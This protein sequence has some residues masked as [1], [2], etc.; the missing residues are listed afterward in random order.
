MHRPTVVTAL[1]F[2][3]NIGE[4]QANIERAVCLL[5][6][7][8]DLSLLKMS[9]FFRTPPWGYRDQDWFVN[10]CALFESTLDPDRLLVACKRI[11]DDLGRAKS[12]RW[13]PRLID[14]DILTWDAKSHVSERLT[15]PH[16]R[17]HERAFVLVP[18]HDIAPDLDVGGKTVREA[19]SLI[20]AGEIESIFPLD[21]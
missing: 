17:L 14:I 11:E 5:D 21:P 18:L 2:G 4:K 20:D 12:V 13:G 6:I 9:R 10:A 8:D 16:P 7:R 3:S 1:A 19:L 15:I